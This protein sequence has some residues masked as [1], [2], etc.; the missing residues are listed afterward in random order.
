MPAVGWLLRLFAHTCWSCMAG[1]LFLTYQGIHHRSD[2]LH[3]GRRDKGYL[4]VNVQLPGC[5][6]AGTHNQA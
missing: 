4:V 3:P 5:G 1:L 6:V 2:R